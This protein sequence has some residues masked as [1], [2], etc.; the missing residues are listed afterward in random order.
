MSERL[1]AGRLAERLARVPLVRRVIVF[2]ATGSTNDDLRRL[3][4][5]GAP[6]GTVVVAE[7]QTA[8]R[9][10]L[11]RTW[12]SPER[13]GLYLSLLF[14]PAEPPELLGR[15][16]IAAAVGICAAC[17]ELAGGGV[18]IKWPNDVL[19]GGRK[20]AGILA[21]LRSGPS[22]CEL[23]MGIGVNVNHEPADFPAELRG[24]ATSLRLVRGGALSRETVIETLLRAIGEVVDRMRAGAWPEVVERFLR[25]APDATGRT[26]RL[27]S[28]ATGI[29]SGLHAS[30]ALSVT[31]ADG[32]TLVHASESV[33]I[34]AR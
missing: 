3:A 17:R 20:L 21:E 31:T 14:R 13:V 27:A 29:T 8:G 4:S 33:T 28:G 16:A 15:Y 22:G 34:L 7:R 10:R 11:G 6:E 23:V 24:Q 26:V 30:G 12:D 19:A 18:V 1:D 25:Y 32:V 5:E 2:D 9:G